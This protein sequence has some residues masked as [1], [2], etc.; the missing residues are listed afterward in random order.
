MDRNR[1][2]IFDTT[3]RDGEQSPGASMNQD[4]KLRIALALED[5]GVDVIEAGFPIASNG[6]FEAVEAIARVVRNSVVCGLA[7]ATRGDIE[8]CAEAIRPAARGRIHTFISTSPLHM[9]YKLQ[10]EPETVLGRVT[11]SVTLARS[12]TDDV[13]WSAEDGSRTEPDFLCRCVEAAIKAGARTINI[14]DTVGYSVP[15][16]YAALIALLINRVPNI[17]QAILSVHCHNDL[18]LAVANS[19]AAVAAGARQIECTINGLGERAGNAAMEEVVMALRTR[20]DRLPFQTGIRTEAITR[21]SRLV[22]TITG[23]AVQPNKAIV[24]KNAFA[25]ESG[26]HQDGVLKNAQTY[27]IM[28]PDSVGLVRSNLVMGKH[29]GRAAFRAKLRDLGYDLPDSA[30]E[31]SFV[32]FKDLADRKKDVFDEDIVALVDDAAV[33]GNDTIK[34]VSLEVL[35]GTRH[36]PPSAELELTIDGDLRRVRATGDGP[37]DATFNAIKALV[38]HD[39]RLQLYQVSAV[40]QGTDAQAEVTVRLEEDGK[41]V[42]GQGAETDTL[43]A[44]ARAYVN[45]LNKLMVK[46]QKT[47]PDAVMA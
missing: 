18:G 26:I 22:S 20:A 41:T 15:D 33:R 24:G 47:A 28:T 13:E 14:P 43:V 27:E 45:A 3:L 35:C 6:D 32:R 31:D 34:F 25:H 16:E 10:M 8:R 36:R 44:S 19:L 5:M 38:P 21:I 9:K 39:A 40:T 4:E 11:E 46:R 29:S 17:D 1:V 42:N 12:L 23:F 37:V 2:I 7:R 30:I